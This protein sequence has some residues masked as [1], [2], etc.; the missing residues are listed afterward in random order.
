MTVQGLC[1]RSWYRMRFTV[2][3]V[4]N[5]F[6]FI[7]VLRQGLKPDG[8]K[9]QSEIGSSWAIEGALLNFDGQHFTRGAQFSCPDGLGR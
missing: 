3:G 8:T 7:D 9:V 4:P 2:F 6:G 1:A 5:S